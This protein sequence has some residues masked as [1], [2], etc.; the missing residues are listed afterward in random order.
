MGEYGKSG[1]GLFGRGFIAPIAGSSEDSAPRKA[2]QLGIPK[3][4][5]REAGVS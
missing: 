2:A 4:T 3:N 1:M 5:G